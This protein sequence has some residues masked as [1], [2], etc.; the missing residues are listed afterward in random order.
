MF[1]VSISIRKPP[2]SRVLREEEQSNQGAWQFK[3]RELSS[4]VILD[5]GFSI[6]AEYSNP[7]PLLRP[8]RNGADV[9][10]PAGGVDGGCQPI[11]V[12]PSSTIL[13][14]LHMSTGLCDNI[15]SHRRTPHARQLLRRGSRCRV[16]NMCPRTCSTLSRIAYRFSTISPRG[17]QRSSMIV[18]LGNHQA[19]QASAK[20]P[21][22]PQSDAWQD[23][24]SCHVCSDRGQEIPRD[25]SSSHVRT[26]FEP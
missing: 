11:R 22:K 20:S 5:P 3:R 6:L 17:G 8:P 24:I 19:G 1:L 7:P 13:L 26:M 4:A 23:G 2:F 14:E 18:L 10:L 21:G 16:P 15:T 25:P 12:P 9:T